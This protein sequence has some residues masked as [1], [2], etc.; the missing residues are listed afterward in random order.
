MREGKLTPHATACVPQELDK[1]SS[2]LLRKLWLPGGKNELSS[3]EVLEYVTRESYAGPLGAVTP[4]NGD[5]GVR[6]V[7]PR[8]FE[9]RGRYSESMSRTCTPQLFLDISPL[10]KAGTKSHPSEPQGR[11]SRIV[12]WDS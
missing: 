10:C 8:L 11:G 2:A 9:L 1:K 5:D 12:R 3:L 6:L 7:T 4:R